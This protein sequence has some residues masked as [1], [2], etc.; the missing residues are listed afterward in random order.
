M[1]PLSQAR[2]DAGG[3]QWPVWGG[4]GAAKRALPL[5]N[6][7]VYRPLVELLSFWTGAWQNIRHTFWWPGSKMSL[8]TFSLAEFTVTLRE[9]KHFC[10]TKKRFALV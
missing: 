7:E 1:N 4:G 6:I 9:E 10:F 5:T 2:G 8:P 3:I